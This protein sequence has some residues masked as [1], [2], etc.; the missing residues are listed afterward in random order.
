MANGQQPSVEQT[1]L[2]DVKAHAAHQA[3]AH[4]PSEVTDEIEVIDSPNGEACSEQLFT[5]IGTA[6]AAEVPKVPIKIRIELL[7]GRNQQAEIAARRF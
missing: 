3:E 4:K 1:N 2:V 5:K 7:P 6:V